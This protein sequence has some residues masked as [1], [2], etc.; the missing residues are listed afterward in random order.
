MVE[1]NKWHVRSNGLN[2]IIM[3]QNTNT[4]AECR[5]EEHA[6]LICEMVNNCSKSSGGSDV[7][8]DLRAEIA[9]IIKDAF[10]CGFNATEEHAFWFF[11]GQA[12]ADKVLEEYWH[13]K[14]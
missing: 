7:P 10:D 14:A 2:F 13:K 8:V 4:I 3:D 5:N 12:L 1:N 11:D 9:R 6:N